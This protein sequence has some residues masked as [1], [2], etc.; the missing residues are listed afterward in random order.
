MLPVAADNDRD[1][2]LFK[3]ELVDENDDE[4]TLLAQLLVIWYVDA[5]TKVVPLPPLELAA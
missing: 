4:I 5:V 1:I 2:G 3:N